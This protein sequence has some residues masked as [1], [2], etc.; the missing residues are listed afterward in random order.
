M[1][2][3]ELLPAIRHALSPA[4]LRTYE[5]AVGAPATLSL[6][7]WNA[8]VSAALLL[9]LHLCEVIMR[10]AIAEA[11]ALRYGPRWPWAEGFERSLPDPVK[12]LNPRRA[13]RIARSGQTETD[14]VICELRFAFWQQM[15]TARHGKRLWQHRLPE[16]FPGLPENASIGNSLQHLHRRLDSLR[17]LRNRIAHHEPIFTRSLDEDYHCIHDLI[18]CRCP[19]TAGWMTQHHELSALLASRPAFGR[20]ISPSSAAVRSGTGPGRG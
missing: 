5:R 18:A 12:G 15:F 4:R 16:V 3:Q 17:R 2:S 20:G 10:N 8:R 19:V 1:S 13:L 14:Q 7:A 11:I 6:Y 9:P